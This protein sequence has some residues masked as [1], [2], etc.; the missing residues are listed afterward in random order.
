MVLRCFASV[1][2]FIGHLCCCRPGLL[3]CCR[4]MAELAMFLIQATFASIAERPTS[5]EVMSE[6]RSILHGPQAMINFGLVFLT[7]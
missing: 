1:R 7:R 4:V 5:D 6:P 2:S 3:C